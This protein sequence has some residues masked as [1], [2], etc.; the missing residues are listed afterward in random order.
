MHLYYNMISFII[1]GRTLENRYGS[2]N[3]AVL[4]A[5]LV[6]ITN[7]FYIALAKF[8][9]EFLEDYSMMR[10][11]AIGFSGVLFALKV[12]TTAET[13]PGTAYIMGLPMPSKYAAWAELLIIHLMVPNA[14]FMGHL[15]GILAGCLYTSTF[16]GKVIDSIISNI[17]GTI[18]LVFPPRALM[19]ACGLRPILSIKPRIT[20]CPSYSTPPAGPGQAVAKRVTYL[21]DF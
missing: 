2:S 18:Y 8:G 9:S 16:I 21:E 13:A 11:C 1:K 14:S 12:I 7:S 20:S 3:F 17:T 4:L 5:F 19:T 10:S 15:A 6:V